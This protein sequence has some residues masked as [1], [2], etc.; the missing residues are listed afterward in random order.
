M[1]TIQIRRFALAS[2]VL[3]APGCASD[4]SATKADDDAAT[5]PAVSAAPAADADETQPGQAD[6]EEL[7]FAAAVASPLRPTDD[8]ARDENRKPAEVLDF[9]GI[10]PGMTVVELMAGR[11]YYSR[12]LG[13]GIGDGTVYVQNNQFVVDRFAGEALGPLMQEEGL[14]QLVRKDV[15]LDALG[16]D[17]ESLDAALMVL[18]YHDTY[19]QEV[20]RAKMNA[21]LFRALKPGGVYGIVDHHAEAGSADRDVK[22][23]HRVDV[24]L[25]KKEILAAGF[26]LEAE[27]DLLAHPDDDRT[28]N[29]FDESLRG[30]TDRFTLRFRKPR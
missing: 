15:E 10:E 8:V 16:F 26:V 28:K 27:S 23:I 19:W 14:G 20:D 25:V 9:F 13:R 17:D 5:E 22:T 21:D 1:N 4:E 6:T 12:I 24:E 18:F 11:G 30:Q 2:L 7:A 3:T 29:V